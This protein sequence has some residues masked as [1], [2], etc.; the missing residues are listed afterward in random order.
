M[1]TGDRWSQVMGLYYVL[2]HKIMQLPN[3]LERKEHFAHNSFV[4]FSSGATRFKPSAVT[5]LL[6]TL[7]QGKHIGAT[8]CR[9]RP[10]GTG[11]VVW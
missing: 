11:P 2:G 1:R 3:E 8:T 5:R 4:L 9:L 6:D 7:K 10:T